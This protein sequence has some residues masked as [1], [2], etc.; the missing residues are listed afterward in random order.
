MSPRAAVRLEQMGFSAVYDYAGGKAD[1]QA[2]GLPVEGSEA[3][4]PTAGT[5]A[6]TPAVCGVDDTVSVA[7]SRIADAPGDGVCV[8][9]GPGDVV[10]GTLAGRLEPEPNARVGDVMTPAPITTRAS[11]DPGELLASM[12]ERG[13]AFVVV[14]DP[15]GR[16]LGVLDHSRAVQVAG[17]AVRDRPS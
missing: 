12:E 16:L 3:E 5:V 11:A 17:G 1:W 6:G 10:V 2:A 7:L 14:T 15:E 4:R 8:V 13:S 9:T